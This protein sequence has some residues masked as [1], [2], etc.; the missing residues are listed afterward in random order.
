M[1]SSEIQELQQDLRSGR[2][3][4]LAAVEGVSE[5]EAHQIPEPGEWTVVQLVAHVTELQPFWVSKAVLIT[6][7]DDPQ[8]TRTAVENDERLA[9]VTDHSQDGLASLIRQM[10]AANDQV[11]DIVGAIDPS[12]LDRPGHREDNPMTAADVI[13]YT[14]RH[15]RLHADQ[16]IE[17]LRLIRQTG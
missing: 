11:V 4:I 12:R 10:N 17:S 3:A 13:R 1:S 16:I 14:A 8:I 9:A 2:D 15:V 6:Q 7:V 5:A